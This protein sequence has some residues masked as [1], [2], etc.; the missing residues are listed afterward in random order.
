MFIDKNTKWKRIFWKT[1]FWV[2]AGL[3][4]CCFGSGSTSH[5]S[6]KN[7]LEKQ[8]A[9]KTK[10]KIVN[11]YLAD[12]D[13]DGTEEAFLVTKKNS[14]T[15]TLWFSGKKQI[16]KLTV[17]NFTL[18]KGKICKV[19]KKQ[20]LFVI[21]G[22][23]GGSCSWSYCLYVKAGKC[24]QVRRSGEGL[25]HI[26]GKDFIV[27]PSAF[28][29][30]KTGGMRAGHTWKPYYIRWTGKKFL[31]YTGKVISQKTLKKYR[32]AGTYLVQIKKAGYRIGKIYSRGNG[33]ININLYKKEKFS[34]NYENVTLRRKVNKVVLVTHKKEGDIVEKSS[35]GGTYFPDA[36]L[37]APQYLGA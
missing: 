20:K 30:V 24:R 27:Y 11:T 10:E 4:L 5:A 17:S 1:G 12:Y 32:D 13:G 29:A 22:W 28:D 33:I 37:W 15:Q 16:K 19:S 6:V 3:V 14:D 7:T 31:N 18:K 36:F 9:K 21:E 35:Y 26:S 2:C 23:G 8:V 25:T 34:V